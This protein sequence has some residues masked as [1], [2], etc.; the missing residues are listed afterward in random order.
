[1][2]A[3]WSFWTKPFKEH[4]HD[5]WFSEKHHLLSWAL[6]FE[7][8]RKHYPE[9]AL[10]T[11]EEGAELLVGHLGLEFEHVSTELSEL[12]DADERW[13]VLGKLRAYCVQQEPFVHLDNDVFLWARL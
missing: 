8:A 5:V 4:H 3:V 9:T 11:D 1:M 10:I 12:R 2:R 6:S 13:W 7:T